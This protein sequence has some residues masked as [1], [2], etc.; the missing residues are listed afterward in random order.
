L[1]GVLTIGVAC[2]PKAHPPARRR[3][4]LAAVV[5]SA[6]I[7]HPDVECNRVELAHQG[8]Y[9]LPGTRGCFVIAHDTMFYFY[10]RGDGLV[11]AWGQDWHVP[12]SARSAWLDTL[13]RRRPAILGATRVCPAMDRVESFRVWAAKDHFMYAF[14]D[15][16]AT[17]LG[18]P[19]NIYIGARMGS[20]TCTLWDRV[21][22][23]L[24][25]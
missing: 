7:A 10:F 6:L 22:A 21:S 5:D 9:L 3:G 12:D 16:K 2:A 11:L 15:S 25:R 19:E 17:E 8:H 1:V 18:V 4:P 24:Y 23:P 13:S 20:P 14:A